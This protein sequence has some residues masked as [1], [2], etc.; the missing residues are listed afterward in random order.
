[1]VVLVS[2]VITRKEVKKSSIS[3]PINVG[4]NLM[5]NDLV[6]FECGDFYLLRDRTGKGMAYSH[7]HPS[8]L[9][10]ETHQMDELLWK[11]KIDIIH[12]NTNVNNIKEN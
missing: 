2:L 6:S 1:M 10:K 4:E 3:Q 12:I 7:L 9:S 8:Q 5:L 11:Y